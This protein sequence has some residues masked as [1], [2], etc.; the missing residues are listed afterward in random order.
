MTLDASGQIKRILVADDN[1]ALR[2][3][4]CEVLGLIGGVEVVGQAADGA[5]AVRLAAL[6]SPDTVLLDLEIPAI[7]AYRAAMLIR[8][9][10]PQCRL[11]ALT[12]HGLEEE[13]QAALSAGFDSV[14]AKDA[15]L[16][17]LLEAIRCLPTDFS[18]IVGGSEL[19]GSPNRPVTVNRAKE[20]PYD[21]DAD[22]I[23]R[24]R[25]G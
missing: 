19:A 15:P 20:G 1:A 7:D 25:G 17:A 24:P 23:R 21:S 9:H 13:R 5:Q 12:V 6:L 11:V 4:L 22:P 3:E 18:S 10:L 8:G 16:E 2:Q 14:V